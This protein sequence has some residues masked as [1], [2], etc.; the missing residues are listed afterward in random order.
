MEGR[1]WEAGFFASPPPRALAAEPA[2]LAYAASLQKHLGT[3]V[4]AVLFSPAG[5]RRPAAFP[6]ALVTVEPFAPGGMRRLAINAR[7]ALV[8][9]SAAV[10][11]AGLKR[12]EEGESAAEQGRREVEVA[13]ELGA[14][15][16]HT[17]TWPVGGGFDLVPN[18]IWDTTAGLICG[19]SQHFVWPI[20]HDTVSV[21]VCAQEAPSALEVIAIWPMRET[22]VIKRIPRGSNSAP[23]HEEVLV[24]G[25]RW[26]KREALLNAEWAMLRKELGGGAPQLTAALLSR[27]RPLSARQP[28]VPPRP[29][30]PPLEPLKRLALATFAPELPM[31]A[32]AD[33]LRLRNLPRASV[34]P[35]AAAALTSTDRLFCLSLFF[36]VPLIDRTGT[37]QGALRTALVSPPP[38]S[39]A[40]VDEHRARLFANAPGFDCM[41]GAWDD[42]AA[43]GAQ[44]GAAAAAVCHVELE[45]AMLERARALWAEADGASPAAEV[46]VMWSGGIDSTSALVSLLRTMDA[47]ESERGEGRGEGD[48]AEGMQGVGGGEGE[49]GGSEGGRRCGIGSWRFARRKRLVIVLDE[50]SIAENSKFYEE[51]IRGQLREEARCG[52]SVSDVAAAG[53]LTVTGELGDQLFG[54]DKCAMAFPELAPEMME[55]EVRCEGKADSVAET[56]IRARKHFLGG[57][58]R[59]WRETL[60]PSLRELG[61]LPY[62]DGRAWEEWVAPQLAL[63]PFPITT[64]HDLLWWLNFS[65]KW[66]S[67]A[68][69]CSHDGGRPLATSL[70]VVTPGG[71]APALSS[72][73]WGVC[74]MVEEGDGLSPSGAVSLLGGVRHFYETRRLELWASVREF[75][76]RKF[77]DIT[78]WTS[79]KEPLKLLIYNFNAEY[80]HTKQ[81]VASLNFGVES[82]AQDALFVSTTLGLL[83]PLAAASASSWQ[84]V[85][86]R[87]PTA[88]AAYLRWGAAGMRETSLRWLLRE[89]VAAGVQGAGTGAVRELLVDPW[90]AF[91]AAVA[92]AAA[93][94]EEGAPP[95]ALSE[96]VA[97][98]FGPLDAFEVR[99]PQFAHTDERQ[100]REFNPVSALTLVGKCAA[101]LP[102]SLVE[103]RTVLDLGACLGAMCHWALCA[104]ASR[105]VAVEVQ[106]DFCARAVE[107]LSEA[108]S[109]WE[110][111]APEK[112]PAHKDRSEGERVVAERARFAVVEAGVRSF[113]AQCDDDAYDVVV[114]AGVLHCFVDPSAIFCAMCRVAR[115]AVVVEVNHPQLLQSAI[116]TDGDLSTGGRGISIPSLRQAA[117][118]APHVAEG[119]SLLQLAPLAIVNRSGSDECYAGLAAV[120]SRALLEAIAAALGFE[121]T[122]VRLAPH[123]TRNSEL[124]TYTSPGRFQ[125]APSRFFLRCER[126]GG[127]A[128]LQWQPA[129]LEEAL[130]RGVGQTRRWGERV[131]WWSFPRDGSSAATVS[132]S[133]GITE[134]ASGAV[135]EAED[136]HVANGTAE[137][138]PWQF[139]TEVASRFEREASLHIP[140][141]AEVVELA[142][143]VAETRL[144]GHAATHSALDVGCATGYT[145]LTLLR[146]ARFAAVH[147]VDK[148]A[149][150]IARCRANL[151]ASGHSDIA[152]RCVHHAA[153]LPCTSR[154]APPLGAVLANW[155]LHFIVDEGERE[156]YLCSIFA[157]LSPGGVLVL[158]DKTA[159]NALTSEM[160][161]RWKVRRGV[162]EAEVA[163]KAASLVGVLVPLPADWYPRTLR[164]L[165]FIDV[166]QLWARFGFITWVASKPHPADSPPTNPSPT[167]AAATLPSVKVA[168]EASTVALKCEAT[169]VRFWPQFALT[170]PADGGGAARYDA[171]GESAPFS[172]TAWGSAPASTGSSW[173]N[174]DA[175]LSVYGYVAVGPATLSRWGDGGNFE[176]TLVAGM[177]FA[178]PGVCEVRGGAG[179]L[180]LAPDGPEGSHR[181][182]FTVGG[183]VV[184]GQGRLPYID[185]CTDTLLLAPPR[186]GA[187]CLNHLHF[188]PSIKQTRHTHP[189]GRVGVII[190]G[191]GVCVFDDQG[192]GVQRVPLV[193]GTAFVIPADAP[194]AF[195]TAEWAELDIVAFHP[196]SDF[197][198]TAADHPMVNRTVVHGIS[199]S[200]LPFIRTSDWLMPNKVSMPRAHILC[201]SVD[202]NSRP[203]L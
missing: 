175:A 167:T 172:F 55:D 114:G 62:E 122:R 85:G 15:M 170:T 7:N 4:T 142:V 111:R 188:P 152:A 37:L 32:L 107:L 104:G 177:Y 123:P 184:A 198:P 130:T 48:L 201:P 132:E 49:C 98:S 118:P 110:G 53:G 168:I 35:A 11:A 149:S 34:L 73:G 124:K 100:R 151:V 145:M 116:H 126:M 24:A 57:L 138:A 38:P 80:Y 1:G 17:S 84:S 47:E 20:P 178:C 59:P 129:A 196:D 66:Q 81:K 21:Q 18:L 160:Y 22:R 128:A 91:D 88:S 164:R 75:H 113:L 190:A 14:A 173:H 78:V 135:E 42:A 40:E 156:A 45:A 143:S 65:C 115:V 191:E 71:N 52:R 197:G 154:V 92:A 194:H 86:A 159:Q 183:P 74:G 148:S 68:L 99:A 46:R 50:E 133:G 125:V 25:A 60:L 8:I 187:P 33:E 141:Y 139:N 192:Y 165:G 120:P 70:T 146:H 186:L 39:R 51:H 82:E 79:Y 44:G 63:A 137:V 117:A 28:T 150:M 5:K 102:P 202:S 69:R 155:T 157:A 36:G 61:L 101:L 153:V 9:E 105:A 161:H 199:A 30:H 103:G 121:T 106:P 67:V 13:L 96:K 10:H 189:S 6:C 140:D 29:P 185:G 182:L 119:L 179:V 2:V 147:G 43:G 176:C 193:P 58:A 109:T 3:V 171:M 131:S 94:A 162:S 16:L 64:T 56:T 200:K 136:G 31:L 76:S 166:E 27:L 87:L 180:A 203:S 90:P 83:T 54:S 23:S 195:E 163:Q 144:G 134:T 93:A 41:R 181:A 95:P 19:P 112:Q 77:S 169:A 89:G 127:S 72:A 97:R 174:R 26:M 108:E 158:T 12:R